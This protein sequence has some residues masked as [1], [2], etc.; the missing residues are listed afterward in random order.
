MP[1]PLKGK[2][3]DSCW[4]IFYPS[5]LALIGQP[6]CSFWKNLDVFN[7]SGRG[8]NVDF[9]W[10][11]LPKTIHR[12]FSLSPFLFCFE[13]LSVGF[14]DWLLGWTV[15]FWHPTASHICCVLRVFLSFQTFWE[16]YNFFQWS[17]KQRRFTHVMNMLDV[18]NAKGVKMFTKLKHCISCFAAKW[19]CKSALRRLLIENLTSSLWYQM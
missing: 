4:S 18:R 19:K 7:T 17:R 14:S 3:A 10:K 9:L 5:L 8:W 16:N 1:H 6:G 11:F 13:R 15:L 2:K 12:W